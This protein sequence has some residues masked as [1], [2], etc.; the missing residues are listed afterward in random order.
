MKIGIFTFHCA[1]NYGAV[2]QCYGLQQYLQSKGHQVYV[3]DY[4]PHYFD[5]Y[6]LPSIKYS[7]TENIKT[8]IKKL[9]KYFTI[10]EIQKNRH[11][12]FEAFI[13][14]RL[15][16][17]PFDSNS[18]YSDFDA[19]ILGS[20]QIW[21]PGIT[22]GQYDEV[23]FGNN[24]RCKTIAYAASSRSETLTDKQ[25]QYLKSHLCKITSIGVREESLK[26]LLQ[27]LVNQPINTVID[28]SFLP[29]VAEYDKL[30]T[31]IKTSR[32]YVLVY[33]VERNDGTSRI[34]NEIARSLNADV[35]ELVSYA[36]PKFC[37]GRYRQESGPEEFLSY[38]KNAE[39]IVTTSFHGMALSLKFQKN[40]YSIRQ[41]T[42]ADLRAESLLSKIGLLERFIQLNSSVTFS[43]IDYSKCL[44]KLN[45]E[46]NLS[47]SFLLNSL[48]NEL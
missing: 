10:G 26:I 45:Q 7:K 37:R 35:I 2:I 36:S 29:D 20:D 4:R 17:I 41:G 12:A 43:D 44:P 5:I 19:V 48:K 27:P 3:I 39:C 11:Q 24:V 18:N 16:L 6:K 33:E 34:A 38:I 47:S 31:P 1:H 25:Q 40:F 8:Y 46:I 9:I 13:T 14:R 22:G 21:N 42:S 32:P 30:C 23:Y 28:P 15:N